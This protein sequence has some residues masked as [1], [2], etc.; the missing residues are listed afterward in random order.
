M[1]LLRL[2]RKEEQSREGLGAPAGSM[3]TAG[4]SGKGALLSQAGSMQK[5]T[6]TPPAGPGRGIGPTEK[7][8]VG[9]GILSRVNQT[10]WTLGK[11]REEERTVSSQRTMLVTRIENI[12]RVHVRPG[13]EERLLL[14][15]PP[16][17]LEAGE[18]LAVNGC[19]ECKE[20]AYNPED[21]QKAKHRNGYR[22]LG[23]SL[24][25]FHQPH[26]WYWGLGNCKGISLD[27][28]DHRTSRHI[29]G[30][31]P[32]GA[33]VEP[34]DWNRISEGEEFVSYCEDKGKVCQS[35]A[36]YPRAKTYPRDLANFDTEHKSA[37]TFSPNPEPHD[38]RQVDSLHPGEDLPYRDSDRL[39]MRAPGGRGAIS[40]GVQQQ[41]GGEQ[42]EPHFGVPGGPALES[43][44]HLE[45]ARR[46]AGSDTWRRNSHF[47]RTAPSTL[48]RS[49]FVQRR[50]SSQGRN[51]ARP[52][53]IR[54]RPENG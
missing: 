27:C 12:D 40:D 43:T 34:P 14:G 20:L 48:R 52:L 10:I 42:G 31:Y 6:W 13:T 39:G 22:D 3:K 35:S 5:M 24:R 45:E 4:A 2:G 8:I 28:G 49:E 9:T 37:D 7:E 41:P 32:N 46:L 1:K 53:A 21:T 16:R 15:S 51:P 44:G 47:R 30:P 19:V 29:P 11:Q 18:C 23:D 17:I 54:M 25:N 26:N 33:S 36:T 38:Y 50:K